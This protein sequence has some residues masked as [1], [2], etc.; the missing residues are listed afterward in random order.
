MSGRTRYRREGWWESKV[1]SRLR[2]SLPLV[3]PLV[4]GHGCTRAVVTG[5]PLSFSHGSVRSQG[6][7]LGGPVQPWG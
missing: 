7:E 4:R 3:N 6:R 2:I 5:H 1:C